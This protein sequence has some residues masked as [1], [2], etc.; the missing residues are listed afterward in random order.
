MP[1]QTKPKPPKPKAKAKE[2]SPEG[3]QAKLKALRREA[4]R[5][6]QKRQRAAA[7]AL[8][9]PRTRRAATRV[10]VFALSL[11][12]VGLLPFYALVRGSVYLHE[13]EGFPAWLALTAGTLLT[14][15]I[16][17][18]YTARLLR[19]ATGGHRFRFAALWVALPVVTFYVVSALVYV[20][21][22]NVKSPEVRAY[23]RSVHPLLRVALA[24]VILVDR[25]AVITDLGRTPADYARMRLPVN[26]T[27]LHYR[28][29]D[30]YV[31]AVDLRTHGRGFARNGLLRL[32]F[33]TM[34][35]DTIRHVGTADHLHVSLPVR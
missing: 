11:V 13:H 4:G 18:G 24:T 9:S 29:K 1:K 34:G 23:Y 35:F 32:Y 3:V 27:T 22:M 26:E 21:S 12:V 25:R 17:A 2:Q 10:A 5:E 14:F 7:R 31:H 33:W 30:G 20:S 28:Q 19:H 15:V 16:V 8:R 6:W